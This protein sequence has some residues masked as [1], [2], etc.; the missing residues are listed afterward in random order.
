[1]STQD[2]YLYQSTLGG[3]LFLLI[4]FL[5]MAVKTRRETASYDK[6]MRELRGQFRR[7]FFE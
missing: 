7:V 2:Y 1:M 6:R 4:L 5:T 3:V